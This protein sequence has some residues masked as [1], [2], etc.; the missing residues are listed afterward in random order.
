MREIIISFFNLIKSLNIYKMVWSKVGE[1][2]LRS[3]KTMEIY[4]DDSD[5]SET[6]CDC[7]E[8]ECDCDDEDELQCNHCE[9]D[10][11]EYEDDAFYY[12]PS[13]AWYCES[14]FGFIKDNE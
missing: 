14:C 9:M 5:D 6:E 13:N 3:G 2:T 12:E 8:G 10:I 7:A 11:G 1:M 4:D